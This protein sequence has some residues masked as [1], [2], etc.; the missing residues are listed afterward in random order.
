MRLN[1]RL[2]PLALAVALM[3]STVAAQDL[4]IGVI[5]LARL[6]SQSPQAQ[7]IRQNMSE[8]FAARR[9]ALQEKMQALK[10]DIKRLK[11]DGSVMSKAARKELKE[12]IKDQRRVLEIKKSNYQDDVRAAKRQALMKLRKEIAGAINQFATNYNYDMILGQGVLYAND[13]V[14]VTDKLLQL[15]RAKS[16]DG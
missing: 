6:V 13:T 8:Q 2:W 9:K 1:V 14:N 7:D 3:S 12:S 10:A 5:N 15:L 11:R 16:Q 4:K